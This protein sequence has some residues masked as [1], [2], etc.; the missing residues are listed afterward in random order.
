M[1]HYYEGMISYMSTPDPRLDQSTPFSSISAM[2]TF[3]DLFPVSK[4]DPEAQERLF[5][6]QDKLVLKKLYSARLY[7]DLGPPE[8]IVEA[9]RIKLLQNQFIL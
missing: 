1:A 3:L 7:Y 6:L 9:C 8:V 4:L 2:Q 5:Q